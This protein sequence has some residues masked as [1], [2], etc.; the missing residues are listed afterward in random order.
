MGLMSGTFR[1]LVVEVDPAGR[2]DF[3]LG[4]G[5]EPRGTGA[6]VRVLISPA[7]GRK[8][9]CEGHGD[10]AGAAAESR[11][12]GCIGTGL[13]RDRWDTCDM[14]GVWARLGL[15]V[16]GVWGGGDL[17]EH[18]SLSVPLSPAASQH[19]SAFLIPGNLTAERGPLHA[20]AGGV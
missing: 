20:V 10:W 17:L 6:L 18:L 8:G 2:V 4:W 12:G 7:S 11:G 1:R 15:D 9:P 14:Y 19:S 3:I 13:G 5:G 16:R